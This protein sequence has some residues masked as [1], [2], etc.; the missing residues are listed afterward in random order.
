MPWSKKKKKMFWIVASA[1]D[2]AAPHHNSSKILLAIVLSTFPIRDESVFIKGPRS[3][4][5][6]PPNCTSL[7]YIS[8]E[9][10]SEALKIFKTCVLV[11]NS[12]WVILVLSLVSP[13]T[14]NERFKVSWISFFIQDFDLFNCQFD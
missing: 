9:P 1:T 4:P 6:N 10:V 8:C 12:W 5:K 3:L 2:T 14:F 11:I 7:D 13:I